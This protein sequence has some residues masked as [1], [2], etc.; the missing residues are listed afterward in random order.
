LEMLL[1]SP[2]ERSSC[3]KETLGAEDSEDKDCLLSTEQRG[4]VRVLV[5]H[6]CKFAIDTERN[7]ALRSGINRQTIRVLQGLLKNSQT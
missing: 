1:I 6:L 5:L 3:S 7:V 2:R 4:R